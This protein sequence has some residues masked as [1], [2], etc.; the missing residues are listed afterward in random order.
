MHLTVHLTDYKKLCF[1]NTIF[2][3]G[4]YNQKILTSNLSVSILRLSLARKEGIL[5]TEFDVKHYKTSSIHF[6]FLQ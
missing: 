4:I 1:K 5:Q 2:C 3:M 6:V